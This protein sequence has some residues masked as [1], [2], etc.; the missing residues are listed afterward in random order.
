MA[1]IPVKYYRGGTSKAL[2][3]HEKDIPSPGPARD[4]TL[5]RIMG[6]PDPMQ[7]DGMGG[8]H[9]VTSK[10]AIIR[11]STRPDVDVDYTFAQISVKDD[12][13]GYGGNCGNISSAVGPFAITEKLVKEFRPGVSP[14]KGLTA[15]LV[16]FYVTGTQKVMEEHVP[17]D[18]AGNVVTAGDFSIEGCPGTGAPILIDCKDTIGGACNRGALPTGNV[19]DTTTVAGKGIECTI[20]DAANIVVFA[21]ASD[22]GINGDEEPGVLDKDT[23][24]LDRIRELRGRAAQNVGLCSSWE[25]IDQVS[26]LPMVALVSRATSSQCHV[27]SRLFLDNKCH[28]AM[29]GTGSVCHAACSRIKGTI[30][31]QLLKPGAEAENVLNIQHPCGFMP[32]AVKVQPQADSVVPGFE[33]LSFIRTA[34]RIFKGELDVPEDIKGVYTEG[35]TADKPQTNGIHTNGGSST[36]NTAGE[37]ATAAIATF[38]SSFTADLLTPNVVQK[39]KELLLDYIGVGCAATVSADSTPAFLSQLKKTATGQTGLS[40]IY[41][42]G[43]SFAPSTAALYN[44]AFAHSLDFDDT[45]MPGA[46]HPGVTVIS[47]VLSQTHI[48]ELKTEDFL[49]ALAVGYETVCRL[50][51]AIGMGGYARGFHNTSTTGIFGAAAAIGRLRGLNQSTIE[52]AFGLALSRA[53]GSM[54]YLENGSWNKRLHPG[55]AASDALLCIDLAEAGV[56]GAAKPIEGK[57]GLLKSYAKGA[58]PA[59][60]D[61]QSLGKKWEFLETAIKP[62]PACRMTH[63]QIEMAATLR[64]RAR[65]RK[66]KTLA[67]GLTKQCVPIVG[68]RQENKIHPQTVVDAQFSS[69]YQTALAYLHGD[70]L[71]WSAYDHI[72]DSTVRELSDKITVEADDALSGLGSWV[73]VEYEDGSVDQDTC[74]YPKGEKQAPIM[75][76]DIKKKYMSLSEPVYGEAKATKIMNLVDEI[77]SLDVAHLMHLLSSRK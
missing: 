10:I 26:F 1:T 64:Q 60:L 43:S 5:Q 41:G 27:Q 18:A 72:E 39:L 9:I 20:C 31:N 25:T 14:E 52:N 16:R 6:S 62:F 71:G 33:T 7:I 66:V 55:F 77:D 45:Y 28:T 74:L 13:I 61:L 2:F 34:R 4:R 57:Y 76:G 15:Q 17:I 49:T 32:A 75:W 3:L 65:G 19:I 29:A 56:V 59:L 53:S 40:T 58:K 37:G 23:G 36:A 46:L 63:G 35:M 54:Q 47:A 11:P 70:T 68:V 22:M 24:L 69:Y 8:T 73:R 21:R 12:Q 30:V 67:V 42:L 51:K 38:A 44:A 50:S 48:Q